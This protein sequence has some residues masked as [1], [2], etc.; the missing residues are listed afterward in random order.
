MLDLIIRNLAQRKIRTGLTIFG[1]TLSIFAVIT[2]GGMSEYFNHTVDKSISLT[3]DKIRVMPEGSG[4]RGG[5]LDESKVSEVK[6][7]PGVSDAYGI[8]STTLDPE[9]ME[10]VGGDLVFGIPPKKQQILMKDAK[11]TSG[12]FL[13]PDDE[14]K[15]V[16]GSSIAKEFN[17][18]VGDKLEIKSKKAPRTKSMIYTKNFT[19]VGIL[20]YT[21]SFFDTVVQIP[22]ENA[23]KFYGLED[24]ISF[25]HAIPNP[26]IDPENLAMIIELSVSNVKTFSPQQI[27]N[28]IESSLIVFSL[29]TL[30]TAILA[31]IIGALSVV[32]TMM[33]SVSERTKEFGIMKAMGA[34]TK[35][36]LLMTIGEATLIGILG[37]FLGSLSG[38]TFIYFL[39]D[40]LAS[41]G[42]VLFIITPRLFIIAILF[43]TLL[44]ILSGTYPAYRAAKMSPMQALRYE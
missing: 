43:A 4:F 17:L 3:A 41:K 20:E 21:G 16:I 34:E 5:A 35:D 23:Q 2:M 42:T 7:V 44:G 36:I 24:S 33:M 19:V 38:V 22:L 6:R 30:S 18:K 14:Y 32:N 13:V 25:I 9:N 1:I 27:K 12:R 15:A 8:L 39:N 11:L 37:G 40:Y 31:S 28:Q 10:L 29:I 26:N